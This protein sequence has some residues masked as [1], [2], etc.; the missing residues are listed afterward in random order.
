[1]TPLQAILQAKLAQFYQAMAE[2]S[3]P[4]LASGALLIRDGALMPLQLQITSQPYVVGWRL[5]SGADG[6]AVDRGIRAAGWNLFLMAEE[7][8][9]IVVGAVTKRRI[10]AAMGRILNTV[11]CQHFNAAEITAIIS[12]RFLGIPYTRVVAHARHIQR[13]TNLLSFG[14]RAGA[15]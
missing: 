10:R 5:V 6:S 8:K 4:L 11:N 7:V 2:H 1:M 12:C 9:S 3:E 14:E 15:T 13:G